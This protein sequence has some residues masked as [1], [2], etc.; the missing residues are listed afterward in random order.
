MV[1]G[2]DAFK[3]ILLTLEPFGASR[4][5]YTSFVDYVSEVYSIAGAYNGS[6]V[7]ESEYQYQ[8]SLDVN[9]NNFP[10]Y[11]AF[12]GPNM[13]YGDNFTSLVRTNLSEMSNYIYVTGYGNNTNPPP[14]LFS[15]ENIVLLEDGG[16]GSTCSSF[17]EY[18]KAQ[19]GV[20][21]V[22]IGGRPQLGPMQGVAGSK[23]YVYP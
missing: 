21:S 17:A 19:G 22:V 8:Y 14:Q 11:K 10:N 6:L 13:I 3:Q 12:V 18:M 1:N 23:G 15:A 9:N 5:R 4:F 16:C 2:Y 7:G 20:R